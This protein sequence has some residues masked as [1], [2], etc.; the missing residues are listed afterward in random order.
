MV[1]R[2]PAD[3]GPSGLM[4]GA[5]RPESRE[6][7]GALLRAQDTGARGE[8]SLSHSQEGGR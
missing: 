4:G 5:Q 3:T 2:S 6:T 7:H 1:P 8:A